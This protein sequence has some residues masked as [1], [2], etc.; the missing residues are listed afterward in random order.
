[1]PFE[2]SDHGVLVAC[3]RWV[4]WVYWCLLLPDLGRL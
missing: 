2:V 4:V 3:V 1:M